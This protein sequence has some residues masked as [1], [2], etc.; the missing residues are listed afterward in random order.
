MFGA[1]EWI[2]IT[3]EGFFDTSSAADSL[4]LSVVRGLDAYS[5]SQFYQA[6][7]RPDLVREKLAGDPRGLLREAAARLDLTKVLASGKAPDVRLAL[8]AR[9]LGRLVDKEAALDA[10][11]SDGGGGIGRVEW[12]VN[13]M[14]AGIDNPAPAA[15]GQPVR[16]TRNLALEPGDNIIEVVAYNNANLIASIPGRIRLAS[17]AS[18]VVSNPAPGSSTAVPSA[19]VAANARL[20]VLAAGSDQYEDK[21]LRL[22]YSVPDARAMAQALAESGKGHYQAVEVKLLSD[23]EVVTGTLDAAFQE[24]SKK[25]LP[26]DVFVLYLAGHG[27]TVDGRYYF[28]PQNFRFNGDVTASGVDAAVRAQGIAQEQWQRWLAAIPARKSV[29]LFDT[30]E[31]GTLANDAA[32][33]KTLERGAANDRLAEA[34][35]RSIMTASSGSAE[36]F[37][38]YHG[39]GLFTYNLL[40]ALNKGDGDNSG[41]IEVTELAA[42]VY[43]QVTSISANVLKRRQEPQMRITLNYPLTRRA[44]VLKE[45][46]S[47]VAEEKPT[48]QLSQAAPLQIKPESGATVVRS[49]LPKTAVTVVS[50][51]GGWSLVAS[52]GRQLGYVATRDLAP[53]QAVAP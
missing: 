50:S 9:G 38:G 33:T 37:E 11:I 15:S 16:L 42:F 14:T 24:L 29:I 47:P 48:Y 34:T 20:F 1:G 44:N 2:A 36:A 10:E 3:P 32:E 49:L 26:T 31:S 46:S 6:L 52:K 8:P 12:R 28:V 43:A 39:H 35:G 18:T 25:I 4:K 27:K 7:Y 13:G 30:C 41:T 40:D 19:A 5:A 23:S 53:L 45:D 51:A 22:R 17:Q 21:S